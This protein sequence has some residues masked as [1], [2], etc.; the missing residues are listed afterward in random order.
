MDAASS[1]LKSRGIMQL[2]FCEPMMVRALVALVHMGWI[3][4]TYGKAPFILNNMFRFWSHICCNPVNVFFR[5]GLSYFSKTMLIICSARIAQRFTFRATL[6]VSS[7]PKH[8]QSVCKC[9]SLFCCWHQ[10]QNLRF[11][12]FQISYV[13]FVLFSVKLGFT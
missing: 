8:L 7:V 10:I 3:A 6:L 13:I 11:L 4:S 12:R 2:V 1:G 9:L 5:E